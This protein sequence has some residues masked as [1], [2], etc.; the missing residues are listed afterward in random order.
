[1]PFY[2]CLYRLLGYLKDNNLVNE[3]NNYLHHF[4]WYTAVNKREANPE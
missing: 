4:E 2:P 1:M 3:D